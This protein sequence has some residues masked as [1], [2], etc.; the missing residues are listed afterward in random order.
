[1]WIQPD[2]NIPSSES[3][4]RHLLYSQN[5]FAEKFGIRVKTGY[6]VDSFGHSGCLPRLLNEGGIENYTYMRPDRNEKDYGFDNQTYRWKCGNN[7][8]LATKIGGYGGFNSGKMTGRIMQDN[9]EY[10]D[11]HDES[12]MK[13]YGCGN[14]GGGPTVRS[15][16]EIDEYIPK[17]KNTFLYSSPDKFYDYIRETTFESLPIYE[18]ELNNHASG[19]YSANSKIKALN[20]AGECRMNEAERMEVLANSV[21]GTPMN[22]GKNREA[23]EKILFNQFH[24]IICGCSIQKAYDEAYS[25]GGAASLT[26]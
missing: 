5:Y 4:A 3:F 8:V 19:C 14:H 21:M 20:R 22:P 13:F 23:W 12:I 15:I 16:M 10:V 26:D 18:C 7:E 25:F 1:M 6:N 11:E 9:D 17:A 2:C 24:D